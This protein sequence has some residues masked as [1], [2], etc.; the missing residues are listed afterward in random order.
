MKR[1]A[2]EKEAQR[3]RLHEALMGRNRE[4]HEQNL[5]G[6]EHAHALRQDAFAH[7]NDMAQQGQEHQN[8]I[9]QQALQPP[10]AKTLQ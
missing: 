9:E 8:A 1:S 6:Q 4:Q 5:A 2:D 3:D 7:Q 10:P